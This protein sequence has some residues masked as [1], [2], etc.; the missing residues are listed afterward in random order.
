MIKLLSVQLYTGMTCHN[1]RQQNFSL[2]EKKHSRKMD[3]LHGW[4]D[5]AGN[6]AIYVR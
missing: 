4:K 5:A 2:N 6:W 1:S 3:D